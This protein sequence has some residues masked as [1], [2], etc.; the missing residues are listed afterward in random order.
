MSG[1]LAY[2]SIVVE[3]IKNATFMSGSLFGFMRA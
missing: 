1:G 3:S 2:Q